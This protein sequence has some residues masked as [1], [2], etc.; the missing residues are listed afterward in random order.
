MNEKSSRQARASS[1]DG[2]RRSCITR[3][4]TG[5]LTAVVEVPGEAL[6]LAL[7]AVHRGHDRERQTAAVG[8]GNV[9]SHLLLQGHFHD[10]LVVEDVPRPGSRVEHYLLRRGQVLFG[11]SGCDRHID[12]WSSTVYS[13]VV[14]G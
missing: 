10:G 4:L 12:R 8:H 6:A 14:A 1:A 13:C 7:L 2:E 9:F 5:R 3:D 11:S